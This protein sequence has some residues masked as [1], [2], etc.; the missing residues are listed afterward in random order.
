MDWKELGKKIA[1]YAPEL[2]AA[3]GGPGGAAIGTLASMVA[4]AF[5]LKPEAE[6]KEIAAVIEK[7]PQAAV[8]LKEIETNAIVEIRRLNVQLAIQQS[9]EEV[10]KIQAVNA[11]MQV[12]SKSEHWPQ[13][14]WRPYW[15]FTSGTAFLVVCVFICYLSYKAVVMKDASAIGAIPLIIGAFASLF[16]IAGAV[17]GITAWGRNKLKVKQMEKSLNS[18]VVENND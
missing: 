12:E 5:G 2:G 3:F 4:G 14:G 10:A 7:D 16:S 6:P 1:K 9:Q 13:W 11:T 8:K 15:G 18:P 17:L